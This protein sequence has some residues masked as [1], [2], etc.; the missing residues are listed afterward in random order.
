VLWTNGN[1]SDAVLPDMTDGDS[2][3]AWLGRAFGL[4]PFDIDVVMITLA[5]ELDLR[6]ERLYA[7]L[8]DDV[9]RKRPTVDLALNLL[10]PSIAAK[11]AGREHFTATA[12]L[13]R[14]GLLHLLPDPHQVQP[15]L[16]AHALKLDEQIVRLLLGHEGL[17]A[18][19]AAFCQ[20]VQPSVSLDDLPLCTE[21]KQTLPALVSQ[22][23]QGHQALRLYFQCPYHAGAQQTA[24]ALASVV[25]LPLLVA[26]LVRTLDARMDFEPLLRLLFREAWFQDAI[27]YLDGLDALRGSE[28]ALRYQHLLDTLAADGGITILRGAEPWVPAAR[29]PMGILSVPF[30]ILDFSLRRACWQA[31]LTATDISLHRHDLN[32]LIGSINA[33]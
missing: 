18:R 33:N 28:Q 4:S 25:G 21:V 8:Q 20:V 16:L 29:A 27:L 11:L 19:L 10:C 5:P 31:H 17:D 6:Y 13:M 3:L 26:D 9:S 23:R 15:P 32:T 1:G 2:R 12:P 22:A 14:H 24:E 7:Y 30:P